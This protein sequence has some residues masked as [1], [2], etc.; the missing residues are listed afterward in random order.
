MH[1][2]QVSQKTT[3]G[4]TLVELIL[5]IVLLGIVGVGTAKFIRSASDIYV[6]L[7]ERDKLLRNATF[8]TERFTREL[9]N[10]VP[11]SIRI[12]GN[13]AVHCI[14]FV[15][16][17]WSSFYLSLPAVGDTSPVMDIVKMTDIDGNAYG[18]ASSDH[19]IV[20]PLSASHVYD[21]SQN[22]RQ[23]ISSCSDDGDGDCTTD[24]DSDGIVQLSVD[25]GFALSSPTRRI[26]IAN[27]SISYCLRNG[28]VYRHE[29]SLLANQ[30]VY[31]SGGELMAE[32]LG[33]AL[34]ANPS[35]STIIS[36]PFQTVG[37]TLARNGYVRINFLFTRGTE[38]ISIVKEVH[39][40]N[41]P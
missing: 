2:R 6:D 16:V 10:A 14:E 21:Q 18:L 40:P 36:D 31:T 29:T 17:N 5:V 33:N 22:R 7:T 39:V 30:Q 35:S 32:G 23:S 26:Y 37:A 13:A 4:F 41:V 34:S 15:P 28:S 27:A 25:D 9:S 12:G 8:V 20:Y 38:Q 3:K 24:D 11:N 19:A 1:S